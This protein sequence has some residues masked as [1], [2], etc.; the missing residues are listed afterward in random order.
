VD[1]NLPMSL[2]SQSH[3]YNTVLNLFLVGAMKAGTS[4]LHGLLELHSQ[5]LMS[6]VKE[7]NHFCLD[8]VGK[9]SHVD[10]MDGKVDA[11]AN[12]EYDVLTLVGDAEKPVVHNNELHQHLQQF[13][14]E[15]IINE[16]LQLITNVNK[17]S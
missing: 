11:I 17:V 13:T 8:F 9:L 5:I 12:G 6:S 14:N 3:V 4:S 1:N 10:E 2:I 15:Q 7:P 16:Y